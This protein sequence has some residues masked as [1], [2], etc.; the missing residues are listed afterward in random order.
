MYCG[1]K[2]VLP[3]GYSSFGSRYNCLRKGV[4]VGMSIS[5][6]Q[7]NERRQDFLDLKHSAYPTPGRNYPPSFYESPITYGNT[8]KVTQNPAYVSSVLGPNIHFPGNAVPKG[9]N[10][11]IFPVNNNKNVQQVYRVNIPNLPNIPTSSFLP[12]ST[13]TATGEPNVIPVLNQV[14]GIP[15]S[16]IQSVPLHKALLAQGKVSKYDHILR[17]FFAFLLSIT[18]LFTIYSILKKL[19]LPFAIIIIILVIIGILFIVLFVYLKI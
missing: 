7:H 11:G 5:R 15:N 9:Y 8:P 19:N 16:T 4:G 10:T 12:G 18:M 13:S 14:E 3:Q 2:Q 17:I 6:G 1:D